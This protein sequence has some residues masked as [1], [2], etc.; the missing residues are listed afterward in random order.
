MAKASARKRGADAQVSGKLLMWDLI[1]WEIAAIKFLWKD[2]R[3][4]KRRQR[5]S[6]DR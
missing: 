6:V 4:R 5:G 2:W 1:L 3:E